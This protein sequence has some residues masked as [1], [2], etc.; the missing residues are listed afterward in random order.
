M[1]VNLWDGSPAG[2]LGTSGLTRSGMGRLTWVAALTLALALSL[3][4]C[5]SSRPCGQ[6][7][8]AGCQTTSRPLTTASLKSRSPGPL[9]LTEFD[10]MRHVMTSR[11]PLDGEVQSAPLRSYNTACSSIDA[12]DPLLESFRRVCRQD[13]RIYQADLR[14]DQC[15]KTAPVLK[16]WNNYKDLKTNQLIA[17]CQSESLDAMT[18][19]NRRF[20]TA[21]TRFDHTVKRTIHAS[22]CRKALEVSRVDL[23]YDVRLDDVIPRLATAIRS[24]SSK[25]EGRADDAWGRLQKAH[26]E[27]DHYDYTPNQTSLDELVRDCSPA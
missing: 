5:G 14:D 6:Q 15:A 1:S 19:A 10:V 13:V 27:A 12:D 21:A 24:R 3:A 25:A 2:Y 20:V 16:A 26:D 9:S 8:G 17:D 23:T 22:R 7:S 11:V 4:A 18:V